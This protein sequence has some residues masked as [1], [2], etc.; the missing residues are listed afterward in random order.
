[1]FQAPY[2]FFDLVAMQVFNTQTIHKEGVSGVL[3]QGPGYDRYIPLVFVFRLHVPVK[4]AE[5]VDYQLGGYEPSTCAGA[6]DRS[7]N[8]FVDG[9]LKAV[10]K[11]CF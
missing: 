11:A 1:M 8:L 4:V 10:N 7:C 9:T 2:P 3:R 5:M 6:H